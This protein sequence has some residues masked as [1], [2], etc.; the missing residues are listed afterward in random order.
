MAPTVDVDA[1]DKAEGRKSSAASIQVRASKVMC[2]E[3][4]PTF[5]FSDDDTNCGSG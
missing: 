2:K 4:F 3:Y 5:N 1:D